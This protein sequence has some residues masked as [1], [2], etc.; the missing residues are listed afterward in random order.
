M[1]PFCPSF[2]GH[3]CGCLAYPER[4][5][6]I[7]REWS[8]PPI[9]RHR[10]WLGSADLY[11]ALSLPHSSKRRGASFQAQAKHA[12]LYRWSRAS[13][14]PCGFC[15]RWV[16]FSLGFFVERVDAWE[17]AP[18]RARCS[19][20]HKHQHGAAASVPSIVNCQLSIEEAPT[21]YWFL[22]CNTPSR[23]LAILFASDLNGQL[24]GGT[25]S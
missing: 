21:T 8:E 11:P 20:R 24:R 4:K 3:P 2:W 10:K 14:I 12:N 18:F 19:I 9:M 7:P 15:L 17:M 23:T 1:A 13:T 22:L 16:P 5:R 25:S 6:R